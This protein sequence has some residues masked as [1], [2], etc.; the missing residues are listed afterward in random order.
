MT[1]E[2]R[3]PIGIVKPY[4]FTFGWNSNL[5]NNYVVVNEVNW[6]LAR[7]TMFKQYGLAW[8]FQYDEEG[9]RP[10]IDRFGLTVVPMGTSSNIK[11][12]A[13]ILCHP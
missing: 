3:K 6:L 13:T 4:Y 10:I 1:Y 8:A 11:S 12:Q 7:E 5:R 2:P 9:A